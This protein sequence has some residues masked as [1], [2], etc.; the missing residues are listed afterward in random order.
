MEIS[1]N[2]FTAYGANN[3]QVGSADRTGTPA[4]N[5]RGN[6]PTATGRTPELHTML[7]QSYR[8]MGGG[9][10]FAPQGKSV[11]L[12]AFE[13]KLN[14][15]STLRSGARDNGLESL[16][17]GL[18]TD[19]DS[20]GRNRM[21]TKD[22]SAAIAMIRPMLS[23]AS[24]GK[25]D[26][27][28]QRLNAVEVLNS[29]PAIVKQ[30]SDEQLAEF[31]RLLSLTYKMGQPHRKEAF[32]ALMKSV[33][34][35]EEVDDRSTALAALAP[36]LPNLAAQDQPAAL[37]SYFDAARTLP[38]NAKLTAINALHSVSSQLS[39][40]SLQ[41]LQAELIK[42]QQETLQQGPAVTRTDQ[43]LQTAWDNLTPALPHDRVCDALKPFIEAMPTMT[44]AQ[45][46]RT[47]GLVGK[48]IGGYSALH[49]ALL[50]DRIA[51]SLNKIPN[52]DGGTVQA[53]GAL[54]PL[55]RNDNV[56]T[57][58]GSPQL[59]AKLRAFLRIATLQPPPMQV[60]ASHM[61]DLSEADRAKAIGL[62][63]A[64]NRA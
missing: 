53:F 59:S 7:K 27:L 2:G 43:A 10:T 51:E 5:S 49:Q 36:S 41:V 39:L 4:P 16:I 54:I 21:T 42:L 56:P 29:A 45:Q 60:L 40:N 20:S 13:A 32:D 64:Q 33:P 61:Q 12:V 57:A 35:L 46:Q 30:E 1:P 58:E 31:I 52:C 22:R 3:A 55:L 18:K 8:P 25:R 34:S 23:T 62:Y 48:V 6:K 37:R 47:I 11:Q 17:D 28:T 63:H 50:T 38:D 9:V 15:W 14:A 19:I 24:M 44:P 26:S